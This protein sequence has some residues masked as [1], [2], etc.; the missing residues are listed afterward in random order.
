MAIS[1]YGQ[2]DSYKSIPTV[3]RNIGRMLS[4]NLF[5]F[6]IYGVGALQVHYF[7]APWNVALNSN[8]PVG[9]YVGYP[10][11]STGWLRAHDHKVLVTVCESDRL[12]G[13]WVSACNDVDQIFVPSEYCKN[14]FVRGGVRKPV[15]VLRHGIPDGFV[16]IEPFV[17]QPTDAPV[18]LHVSGAK[19]FP[20]RK[21][22]GALLVAFKEFL[23]KYPKAQLHLRMSKDNIVGA[24]A[25]LNLTPANIAIL[26]DKDYPLGIENLPKF[27]SHYDCVIQP[28]RAEG[29][30]IVPLEAR[31]LGVPNILTYA[32]G[33]EEHFVEEADIPVPLEE[34]APIKTQD[35][36]A[37]N[38]PTITPGGILWSL[39]TYMD[40]QAVCKTNTKAWALKHRAA[41]TWSKVLTPLRNMVTPIAR[42]NKAVEPGE[43]IIRGL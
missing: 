42:A 18:F 10:T 25:R 11:P 19:S 15:S 21:G 6:D 13:E 3:S 41:W 2:F 43:G 30:G 36:E 35:N 8:N 29:F 32:T 37:G 12:P 26:D 28:S 38:A 33:H 23:N 4:R 16:A 27:Y 40:N 24:L 14:V 20:Q 1:L 5:K 22:T 9:I 39:N 34:S 7:D 17:K 31:A